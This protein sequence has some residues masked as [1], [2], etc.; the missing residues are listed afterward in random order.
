MLIDFY[1]HN[2]YRSMM[3]VSR[4]VLGAASVNQCVWSISKGEK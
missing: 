3:S 1:G 2:S 4:K